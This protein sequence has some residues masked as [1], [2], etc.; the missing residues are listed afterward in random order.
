MA[1]QARV[2]I[3]NADDFGR[4]SGINAG[5]IRAHEHGIVTSAGVMVRWP[6][7]E[8]A[9]AYAGRRPALSL[10]L[11]VDLGEWARDR[12][13]WVTLYENAA[14]EDAS[15]VESEVR[16]QL[17]AFRRLAGADPTHLDSHQHLHRNGGVIQEVM[18]AVGAE[19]GVPVRDLSEE[20]RYCGDFYGQG[21]SGEPLPDAIRAENLIALIRTLPSG[22][23]E[24]GCHPGLGDDSDSSYQRERELEVAALCD[25]RV[26]AALAEEAIE[27]RSFAQV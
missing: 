5:V 6:A 2:L 7:A 8:E 20:V 14:L 25:P 15:A 3:V 19:L 11:H 1:E 27:L 24:L 16:A 22:I 26:G 23:T 13:G 9:F 17:E 18:R 10:G 12:G 4:S 21:G